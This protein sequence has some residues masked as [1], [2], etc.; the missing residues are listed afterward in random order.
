MTSPKSYDAVVIGAG[1]G[2]YVA[3]IRLAQEGLSVLCIDRERVGGVCLNWGCIPSKAMI[4]ASSLVESIKS[5]D[6]MGISVSGVA[7]DMAKM[8]TWK[9]S[10]VTRLTGGIA[11]LFKRNGVDLLMGEARFTGQ[12]S[13]EEV[14]SE[15]ARAEVCLVYY[16]PTNVNRYRSSMKLREC[17]AMGKRVVCNSFDELAEVFPGHIF[18]SDEMDVLFLADF[19]DLH[20]VGMHQ[21]RGGPGLLKEPLDVTG[22]ASQLV[23]QHLQSDLPTKRS[24]LR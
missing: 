22:I 14:A 9:D 20:D 7:V 5:A 12:L 24:L 16:A 13:T 18:L 21:R 4:A 19:V 17:L 8:K 2:G 1:P 10:I 15:I 6:D 11:D 3:A 23:V